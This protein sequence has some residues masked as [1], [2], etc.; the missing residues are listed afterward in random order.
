MAKRKKKLKN[1]KTAKYLFCT[2]CCA[3]VKAK[4]PHTCYD[5]AA[6]LVDALISTPLS[7][8][9]AVNLLK[10]IVHRTKVYKDFLGGTK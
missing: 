4:Q 7:R 10:N 1:S 2:T 6:S 8:K 9:E 3:W 5:M